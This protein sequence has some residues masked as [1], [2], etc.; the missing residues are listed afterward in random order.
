MIPIARDHPVGLLARHFFSKLFDLEFL[1]DRAS[2]SLPRI[3]AGVAGMLIAVGLIL[4]RVFLARYAA[5]WDA[6]TAQAWTSAVLTDHVFTIAAPMWIV[7]VATVTIGQSLFPDE[8][9]FRILTPLPTR[10]RDIFLAKI[11]SLLAFGAV[12]VAAAQAALVP[13]LVLSG[14]GPWAAVPFPVSVA[15]N[16]IAGAVGAMFAA[17]AVAAVN[18]LLLLLVPRHHLQTAAAAVTSLLLFALVAGLPLLGQLPAVDRALADHSRWVFFYPPA[19]FLGIE[20]TLLGEWQHAPL[21]AAA[22]AA[23]A[24]TGAI[25]GGAFLI[26][27]R[28]FDRILVRPAPAMPAGSPPGRWRVRRTKRPARTAIRAFAFLTLGRS[29]F[30]QGVV[31]TIAAVGAAFALGSLLNA[32][33]EST[34]P[35]GR[36]VVVQTVTWVPMMLVFVFTLAVRTALLVPIDLRA[37]WVLRMTEDPRHRFDALEGAGSVLRLLGVACPIA[38]LFPIQWRVLGPGALVTSAASLVA[39][40]LFV[41]IVLLG[42]R[43]LPF[44]CSYIVGKRTA[45]LIFIRA[46]LTFAVFS[47]VS[48]AAARQS[49]AWWPTGGLI[50]IGLLGAV[51]IALRRLRQHLREAEPLEFEDTL[52]TETNPLRLS[53]Y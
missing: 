20:R 36:W 43:R 3:V 33:F 40:L 8:A 51:V 45:P 18:A 53:E 34:R 38:I 52:P 13:L 11:V 49:L 46:F 7:A 19:W 50:I 48:S 24:A 31:V 4:T 6:A 41:E 15:A 21:A 9:D 32:N 44:T 42:W 22:V 30:H 27:Y 2:Q 23:L 16:L 37:N 12:F 14:L 39:G 29:V 26:L 1:S 10:R 17:L 25:A 5:L 35:W 28:H 47:E